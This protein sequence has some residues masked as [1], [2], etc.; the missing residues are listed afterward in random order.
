MLLRLG[1]WEIDAYELQGDKGD[2]GTDSRLP[3][4]GRRGL[5]SVLEGR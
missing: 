5:P 4:S 3:M 1:G 2:R